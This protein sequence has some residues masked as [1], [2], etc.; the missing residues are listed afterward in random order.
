V[1]PG[2]TVE[3]FRGLKLEIDFLGAGRRCA[4]LYPRA[5]KICPRSPARKSRRLKQRTTMYGG[6]TTLKSNSLPR[7]DQPGHSR[8]GICYEH[9]LWTMTGQSTRK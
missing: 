7:C 5:G 3:T 1:R 9:I 8:S 2:S 6:A 4:V